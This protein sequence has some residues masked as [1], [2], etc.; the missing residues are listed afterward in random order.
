MKRNLWRGLRS[1]AIVTVP[2]LAL[3]CFGA[4]AWQSLGATST[5]R[6][7]EVAALTVSQTTTESEALDQ[8]E[9]TASARATLLAL[10]AAL[11]SESARLKKAH[12]IQKTVFGQQIRLTN[13][14]INA[15]NH[16]I[17]SGRVSVPARLTSQFAAANR[18]L[19]A[20]TAAE[21]KTGH[22]STFSFGPFTF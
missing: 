5:P 9:D 6:T 14:E 11:R 2:A 22:A 7:E 1:L 4:S 10:E 3:A 15:I 12:G 18:K 20:V 17:R 13:A 19:S 21:I 16:L 8:W